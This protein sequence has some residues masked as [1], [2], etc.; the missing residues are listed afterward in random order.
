[1]ARESALREQRLDSIAENDDGSLPTD[2]YFIPFADVWDS[3][4]WTPDVNLNQRTGGG[5]IDPQKFDRGTE[6]HTFTVSYNLQG[7]IA[8]HD[9]GG[10]GN[11]NAPPVLEAMT[12]LANNKLQR[13]TIVLKE[14]HPGEGVENAGR[15]IFSVLQHAAPNTIVLSGDPENNTPIGIEIE[16]MAPKA[17]SHILDQPSAAT[18]LTVESTQSEDGDVKIHGVDD[19]DSETTVTVSVAGG[20]ATTT[21]S[22][23]EIYAVWLVSDFAGDISVTDGSGTTFVTL[24]GSDTYYGV[25]GDDGIPVTPE[26]GGRETSHGGVEQRFLGN[27]I[28]Y[29]SSPIA[30]EINS[31]ELEINNNVDSQAAHNQ[32]GQV[33]EAGTRDVTLTATLAGDKQSHANIDNALRKIMAKIIWNL[34]QDTIEVPN[35]TVDDPGSRVRDEEEHFANT[36]VEFVG[37]GVNINP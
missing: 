34:D 6:T 28:T 22:F 29:N 13:R 12:R 1:M 19:T 3:L 26:S 32:L 5:N 7:A 11:V 14:T 17:R 33:L 36:D 30:P 23:K 31:M 4:D 24:Y 15:S 9:I 25:E 2:G 16:Y 37:Q 8:A 10:S 27:S 35:A 21:A 18:T 20:S